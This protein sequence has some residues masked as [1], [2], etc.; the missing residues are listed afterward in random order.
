M[1]GKLSFYKYIAIWLLSEGVAIRY[2]LTY[3]G[4]NNPEKKAE[5]NALENIKVYL[6]ETATEFDHYVQS[7]NVNTNKWVARHIF[8]R[9]IFLGNKNV[10]QFLTLGFLAVWHGFHTGYYVTFVFEFVIIHVDRDVS[11]NFENT[12]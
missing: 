1:F 5:W 8:K 10:S 12:Q 7:F 2:G 11:I 4:N 9:L 6:F 3:N